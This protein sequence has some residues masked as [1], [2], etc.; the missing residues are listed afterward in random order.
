MPV[1]IQNVRVVCKEVKPKFFRASVDIIDIY[2]EKQWA[3]N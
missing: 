3:K 2:Q 1:R